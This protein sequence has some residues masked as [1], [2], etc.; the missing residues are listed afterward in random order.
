MWPS[1]MAAP[2]RVEGI[3]LATE[4]LV[5]SP[6]AVG[7]VARPALARSAFGREPSDSVNRP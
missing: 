1:R 3:D 5:Q 4:R 6:A 7:N 2:T